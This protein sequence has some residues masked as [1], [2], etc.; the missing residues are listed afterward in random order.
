MVDD[1]NRE[2][3]A[4]EIGR[5]ALAPVRGG[6]VGGAGMAGAV[7]HHDRRSADG[8]RDAVLDIHLVDGDCPGLRDAATAVPGCVDCVGWPL[9]KKL[10]SSCSSNG[11]PSDP[12]IALPPVASSKAAAAMRQFPSM[13]I[14]DN[15]PVR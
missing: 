14:M 6:L 12:A 3:L 5:P 1:V 13:Q 10:P 4:R 7:H 15:L 2:A 9:T 11:P 8:L